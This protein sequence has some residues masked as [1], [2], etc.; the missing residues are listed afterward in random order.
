MPQ[1]ELWD[2]CSLQEALRCCPACCQR[3]LCACPR[4]L[5]LEALEVVQGRGAEGPE[6]VDKCVKRALVGEACGARR[7]STREEAP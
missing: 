1:L 2:L 5:L 3:G 7:Q 6:E 4:L